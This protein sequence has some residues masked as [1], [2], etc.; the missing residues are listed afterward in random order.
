MNWGMAL[1][2]L[3]FASG[4]SLR[5]A[6]TTPTPVPTALPTRFVESISAVAGGDD[7]S[8]PGGLG[9]SV[10]SFS[11][12]FGRPTAAFAVN[13]A[14]YAYGEWPMRGL[15]VIL[16]DSLRRA[17]EVRINFGKSTSLV[18]AQAAARAYLPMDA[19]LVRDF[20]EP[21]TGDPAGQYTSER[22]A[23]VFPSVQPA[24]AFVV[25][26]DGQANQFTGLIL[27]V[28]SS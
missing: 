18:E 2:A 7:P 9:N 6:A 1:T 17:R 24:G 25:V 4:C 15:Y 12:D 10:E 22:L 5:P 26:Y 20:D 11:R 21:G 27:R 8:P 3:L 14:S 28:R 19:K 16:D 23:A 13:Q